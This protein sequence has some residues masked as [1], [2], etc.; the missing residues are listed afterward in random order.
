MLSHCT[1]TGVD[2]ST[3]LLDL[4]IISNAYGSQ[5]EWGVLYSEDRQGN[6]RY[7]SFLTIDKIAKDINDPNMLEGRFALH[8]CG[9]IS[10]NKLLYGDKES[11]VYKT[12]MAFPT[13]Q[14]NLKA[15]GISVDQLE[16][17]IEEHHDKIIIT[18]HNA[19]NFHLN[20]RLA[21]YPN[22][23]SLVDYSGGRGWFNSVVPP[24]LLGDIQGISGGLNIDNIVNKMEQVEQTLPANKPYWFDMESGVRDVIA[25]TELDVFSVGDCI[26]ILKLVIDPQWHNKKQVTLPSAAP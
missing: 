7:P 18:Q 26:R 1:F 23:R 24:V 21:K 9:A 12:A 16:H 3:K 10:I 4:F 19:Y 13:I 17:F 14:L 22:H 6:G 20:K 5:V 8:V 15:D 25:G 2:D 11:H